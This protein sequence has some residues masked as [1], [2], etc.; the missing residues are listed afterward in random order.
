MGIETGKRISEAAALYASASLSDALFTRTQQRVLSLLFGQPG[1][2]MSVSDL[3]QTTGAGSGAVQR[4]IARLAGSGL[5]TAEQVGNQK[6][7][8]SNRASPI[9]DELVGIVRKTFGLVVP[10]RE[11]LA[12]LADRI[13]AAFV[14]GSV[15]KRSDSA[16]SDIDLML[17]ADA[18]TYTDVLTALYPL[19]E[20]LGR[21]INPALYSRAE[22]RKRIDDGNGFILRVL[23]QPKLWLIGDESDLERV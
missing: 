23:E 16:A 10:L 20:Q 22:L 15:A 12:P 4:E 13:E 14:F 11:A 3:I 18:L 1:R 9:H 7:Y 17:I 2:T 21:D 5:L 6:R 8:R 19:I